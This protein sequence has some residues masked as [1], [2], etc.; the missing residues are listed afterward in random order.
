MIYPPSVFRGSMVEYF[1]I[2]APAASPGSVRAWLAEAGGR[3]VQAYGDRA[4]IV[5]LPD[6]AEDRFPAVAG[7]VGI[8]TGPVPEDLSDLDEVGRMGAAAWNL[9]QSPAFGRSRRT[10]IGEGRSW[11][12][13][14][15]EP[16][17]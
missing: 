11:G 17:G 12:D 3:A 5:E 4:L 2:L 10:R 7:I 8:H 6:G 13:E 1:V 16:E 15:A 14:E 9:R